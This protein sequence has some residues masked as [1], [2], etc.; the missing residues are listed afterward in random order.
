MIAILRESQLIAIHAKRQLF[1]ISDE[2]NTMEKHLIL[3]GVSGTGKSSLIRD[4]LGV[5]MAFA[6]G[7]ITKRA[8]DS[9]GRLLGYDLLPSSAAAGVD[10]YDAARF[11]NY[12]VEPPETDNE[13]FRVEAVRLLEE[14][15]YYPF[16]LIDEFGGF[17]LIIPQFRNALVGLLNS[18]L[19]LIGV[20][21]GAQN[22]EELRRHLG[23]GGKY[24]AYR[25]ALESALKADKCTKFI[26]VKRRGDE[27]ARQIV[28]AWAKEYAL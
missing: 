4:T 8:C 22:G 24:S 12:T 26:E 3:T 7:F 21:K 2:R 15:E 5:R 17:E 6:G 9:S 23:L 25:Q 1:I 14:A 13:V 11:L 10:G 28:E 19:P 20:L 27:K 18:E 16:A